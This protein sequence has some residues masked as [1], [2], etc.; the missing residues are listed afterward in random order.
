MVVRRSAGPSGLQRWLVG[1]PRAVTVWCCA[2]AAVMLALGVLVLVR[3]NALGG[4]SSLLT[5]C[6]AFTPRL[7][8]PS[9]RRVVEQWDAEH[10]PSLVEPARE[11]GAGG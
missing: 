10:G 7:T 2:L 1:H 11:H 8:L 6:G 5:A 9:H 3:G 4:I